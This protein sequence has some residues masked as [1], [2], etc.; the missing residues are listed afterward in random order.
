MTDTATRMI[1]L[2]EET[3]AAGRTDAVYRELVEA[4]NGFNIAEIG[5]SEDWIIENYEDIMYLHSVR[6]MGTSALDVAVADDDHKDIMKVL[7]ARA[8][9]RRKIVAQWT[10]VTV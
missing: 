10:R 7:V 2:W 6:L 3:W 8:L 4:L 1:D 9:T 5:I